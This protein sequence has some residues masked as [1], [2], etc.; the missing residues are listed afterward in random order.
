MRHRLALTILA[1]VAL[2]A[3]AIAQTQYYAGKTVELIVPSAVGGATGILNRFLAP[4][5]E[6]HIPGGPAVQIRNLPRRR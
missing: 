6:R 4:F 2:G 1:M 3:P 5:L